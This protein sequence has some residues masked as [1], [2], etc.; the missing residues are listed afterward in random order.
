M[1]P[2]PVAVLRHL[3][4]PPLKSSYS[5]RTPVRRRSTV[6]QRGAAFLLLVLTLVLGAAAIF[7]GFAGSVASDAEKN[8]K[9]S[10]ALEQAKA[11]LIGYAV[12][13]Y[14]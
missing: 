7:Y 14:Q 12:S 2:T 10:A 11:A 6:G 4:N 3:L 9:T 5:V 1:R 8:K 13:G